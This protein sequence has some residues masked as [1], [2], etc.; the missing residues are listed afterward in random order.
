MAHAFDAV[1]ITDDVY[2]V[3]AID[4]AIR[5]FHGY[6]TGRG[7]TYNA[8]L[9]LADKVTLIDTVKAPFFGEMLARIASVIDPQK[10]DYI[11]SNHTEMDHSGALPNTIQVVKPEKVF[12][13]VMGAKGLPQHFGKGLDLTPVKDGE[14]L[15]L[16]NRTLAFLET[17]MLHWPDSMFSY[18]QEESLLFS[19]D[20]FGMH[21]AS[22]ERFADQIAR[23]V[24]DYEAGKYY[25]NI[26]MPLSKFVARLLERVG[27]LGL[28]PAIVAPDHGPVWRKDIGH[29][30]EAYGRWARQE[31]TR[32]VVV[33]YDTMWQSTGLMA[34]TIA[35]GVADV[36]AE[37]KVMPLRAAHRSDVATELLEAGALIVGSP[38][39][40]NGLFPTV[41]DLL[42][43]L[44]GLKP[45]NLVGAAFGSYGWS[46]EAFKE[47]ARVLEDMNVEPVGEP[48]GV[49]Y[50]PDDA[51][52]EQCRALGAA[53]A[54]RVANSGETS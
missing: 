3:G 33:S 54:E 8:Y 6:A 45:A 46:G 29:I 18:L 41:A 25:A 1:K 37:V 40:N 13:S 51:A 22:T 9:I 49:R 17:R 53:V 10:I 26:L 36:G 35:Q 38:T 47:V 32:K 12:A 34:R 20:A 14:T 50:V 39:I 31:P 44:K 28:Q 42:C 27:G 24:L 11:V 19:Q 52:L 16:G 5:D 15:S 48:L 30:V 21:L 2:W 4:W 23:D 43:Y 7:S